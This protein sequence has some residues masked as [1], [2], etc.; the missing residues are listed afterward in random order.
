MG[1]DKAASPRMSLPAAL[2]VLADLREADQIVVTSMGSAREWPRIS[3]HPLDFHYVP[4]T[5]SGAVPLSLGLALAQPAREVLV[6]TG[7][8]SLLMS[9]GCLVT[10]VDSRARNLTIVLLDNGVY[11]I[12][13]GQKTAAANNDVD[14]ATLARAVGFRAVAGFSD[15]LDWRDRAREVLS[16]PGPR[17]IWLKTEP[18]CEDYILDP[19]C[20]MQKQLTRLRTALKS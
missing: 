18:E 6:C 5:M 3:Q 8:G 10:V 9:L 17:F 20:A 11:E 12:T 15:D 4:S 7:D 16:L 19:P 14:F 13:G 1:T 2:R